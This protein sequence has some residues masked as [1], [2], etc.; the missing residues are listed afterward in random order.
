M[1]ATAGTGAS[2][3]ESI[4]TSQG[5][6]G[7][8]AWTDGTAPRS[9]PGAAGMRRSR[10]ATYRDDHHVV[11]I[12][13]DR[14]RC[15]PLLAELEELGAPVVAFPLTDARL[16]PASA[17]LHD[18]IIGRKL[19]LPDSAELREQSARTTAR[20]V[21]RGWRV[22]GPGIGLILAL[23]MA[24]DASAVEEPETVILGWA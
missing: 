20:Q 1:V 5:E 19:V 2:G 11:E 6:R 23:A 13:L 10:V 21:R 15:Q 14:W 22:D 7:S 3:S 17:R 9:G 18:A 24:L 4:S 12:V 8:V 16:I